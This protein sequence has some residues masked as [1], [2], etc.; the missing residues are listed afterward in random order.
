MVLPVRHVRGQHVQ[1]DIASS[2]YVAETAPT[3]NTILASQ[4]AEEHHV[5]YG[6]KNI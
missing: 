6:T 3:C 2:N 5:K 4:H 1:Y